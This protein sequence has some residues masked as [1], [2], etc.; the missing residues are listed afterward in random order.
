M[1]ETPPQHTRMKGSVIA[2]P[3][4]NSATI[5]WLTAIWERVL[6]RSHLEIDDN[7]FECG[8]DSLLA[9]HV[10][11]EIMNKTGRD[12]PITTIYDAPTICELAALVDG[13]P[14][15]P[16][17][18]LVL[19][20][21]GSGTPPFFLVHGMGG[22]VMQ[23]AQLGKLIDYEGPVYNI[24][25]RGLDGIDRP[26]DSVDEMATYYLKS[27]SEIQPHGPYL[28]AGYSFGGLVAL[29]MAQR[30]IEAG[31]KVALLAF[32]DSYAIPITW[33]LV[34]RLG[35]RA[36]RVRDRLSWLLKAPIGDK[37]AF[38]RFR[39]RR[40][41][42][43][44]FAPPVQQWLSTEDLAVPAAMRSVQN[45][46]MEAL[47]RYRPNFY[48]GKITFVQPSKALHIFP[49]NPR[50][51][52]GPHAAEIEILSTPGDHRSQLEEPLATELANV[53]SRSIKA[54]LRT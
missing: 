48:S 23:L 6:Q 53:L 22:S 25:P 15:P 26:L 34:I 1:S 37:L 19:A 46:L 47:A 45:G 7:F 16:F 44:N 54:A 39:L 10:F 8:G 50:S 40:A 3:S 2:R 11:I 32:L 43:R 42:D 21:P 14:A 5:S 30:L 49:R 12:L 36:R 38:I 31:H 51:V 24:Q 17:S 52:W 41:A 33:P 35:V 27:I 18:P 29:T 13:A 28:L 20:K 4:S 9:L